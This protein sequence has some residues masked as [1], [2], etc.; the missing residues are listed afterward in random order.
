M[1][2]KGGRKRVDKPKGRGR[3][4]TGMTAQRI[5]NGLCNTARGDWKPIRDCSLDSKPRMYYESQAEAAQWKQ[6]RNKA[7]RVNRGRCG[8]KKKHAA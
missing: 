2:T 5:A 8:N 7:A 1:R 3:K 6:E 4:K